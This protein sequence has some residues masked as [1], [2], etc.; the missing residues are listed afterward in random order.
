MHEGNN[1]MVRTMGVMWLVLAVGCVG[2][3]PLEDTGEVEQHGRCTSTD[4]YECATDCG[5]CGYNGLREGSWDLIWGQFNRPTLRSYGLWIDP[6]TG[7]TPGA[8][9][10]C[11][12]TQV[13]SDHCVMRT[14]YSQWIADS[15][16]SRVDIMTHVVAAI[17]QTNYWVKDPGT[18]GNTYYGSFNLR[19]QALT[20]TWDYRTQETITAA[21]LA[22]L[23]AVPG[24]SICLLNEQ[25]PY[26]CS[27]SGGRYH[28]S[29]VYGNSFQ[30]Y[31]AGI[32]GGTGAPDPHLNKRFGAI[33]DGAE[34]LAHSYLYGDGTRCFYDGTGSTRHATS[35]LGEN[36]TW[37]GWP[38]TVRTPLPPSTWYYPPGTGGD[39]P[40]GWPKEPIVY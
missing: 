25:T 1:M 5:G 40:D 14:E 19:P 9:S 6:A 8:K 36:G 12:P 21:L 17:A 27:S 2:P 29:D 3:T 10:L 4:G 34:P 7:V 32:S 22:Q 11:D 28:E 16:T 23:N 39:P 26:N 31:F 33:D 13:W 18:N 37:W 38:V 24:V 30:Y 15:Q 20:Q 35:C